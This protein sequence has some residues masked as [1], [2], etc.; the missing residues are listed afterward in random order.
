MP[1]ALTAAVPAG[2]AN[3]PIRRLASVRQCAPALYS[4]SHAML[5]EKGERARATGLPRVFGRTANVDFTRWRA[6]WIIARVLARPQ[7]ARTHQI[8]SRV[9]YAAAITHRFRSRAL[10]E[11]LI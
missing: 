9:R 3:S 4:N 2:H 1:F 7:S 10:L 5:A 6:V 8:R 11:A